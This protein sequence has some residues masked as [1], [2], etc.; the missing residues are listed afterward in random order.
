MAHDPASLSASPAAAPLGPVALLGLRVFL[1]FALGFFISFLF[2]SANAVIGNE[3]AS[4]FALSAAQL[5]L[6][7]SVYFLAFATTQPLVGVLLD[8]YGPR[9]VVPALLCVAAAGS[10]VF[11]TATGFVGLSIARVIIGIGVSACL[12]GAIKALALWYPLD[13]L[14]SLTGW[15]VAFGSLG[16]LVATTPVEFSA[17]TIGWRATFVVF[18]LIA[19]SIAA[20]IWAAVPRQLAAVT[21][22]TWSEQWAVFGRIARTPLFWR[23]GLPMVTSQSAFQGLFGL[24]I[25]PWLMDVE[26]LSRATAATWLFWIAVSALIASPTFGVGADLLARRGV[27]RLLMLKAGMTLSVASMLLAGL[28]DLARLPLLIAFGFGTMSTVLCYTFVAMLFPRAMSGRVTTAINMCMFTCTFLTQW[29]VGMLLQPFARSAGGYA[30]EGYW[31]VFGV[32]GAIQCVSLVWLLTL[33][34]EPAPGEG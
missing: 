9:R 14:A 6:L 30:A 23:L 24:W 33:R 32:L 20:L 25:V 3:L 27:P 18:A 34:R 7:T 10:L 31:L 4:T 21:P 29:G 19:L 11:A 22:A 1:P 15:V 13:R 16:A 17:A 8:R 12:M 28:T 2:R 5:G 26:D